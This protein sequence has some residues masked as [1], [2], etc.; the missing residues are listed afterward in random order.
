MEARLDRVQLGSSILG[1]CRFIFLSGTDISG[2]PISE[3][4]SPGLYPQSL[5]FLVGGVSEP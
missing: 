4:H 3:P 1:S 5:H 2:E